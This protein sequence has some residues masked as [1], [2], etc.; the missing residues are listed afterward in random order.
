MICGHERETL[1]RALEFANSSNL[2]K[3]SRGWS[4]PHDYEG[5]VLFDVHDPAKLAAIIAELFTDHDWHVYDDDPGDDLRLPAAEVFVDDASIGM[6]LYES[7][8]D[9]QGEPPFTSLTMPQARAFAL[10][11]LDATTATAQDIERMIGEL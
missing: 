7:W 8:F 1:R 10:R 5:L 4:R 11:L 2:D 9:C 6:H 3:V